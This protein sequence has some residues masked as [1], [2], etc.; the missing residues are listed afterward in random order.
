MG[1]RFLLS[2]IGEPI[3]ALVLHEQILYTPSLVGFT[4][5][6]YEW[7]SLKFVNPGR[8]RDEGRED[9]S[10]SRTRLSKDSAG[11]PAFSE[12]SITDN[13]AAGREGMLVCGAW[14]GD[15]VTVGRIPV[16]AS[17]GASA[18]YTLRFLS[19]D[20]AFLGRKIGVRFV[21]TSDGRGGIG[22]RE[23]LLVRDF[24]ALMSG[25]GGCARIAGG[26]SHANQM[27]SRLCGT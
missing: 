10:D 4:S 26:T 9:E 7:K 20:V 6:E 14:A 11:L 18:K 17:N 24:S 12:E 13:R 27:A 1:I 3:I 2:V 16:V 8:L 19:D 22:R 5:R 15:S 25:A 21:C 23:G